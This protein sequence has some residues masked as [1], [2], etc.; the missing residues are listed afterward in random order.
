MS[1]ASPE[2]VIPDAPTAPSDE[3]FLTPPSSPRPDHYGSITSP[4]SPAP[5]TPKEAA[6]EAAKGGKSKSQRK[7]F[8]FRLLGKKKRQAEVAALETPSLAP[9][10]SGASSKASGTAATAKEQAPEPEI[11]WIL[12]KKNKPNRLFNSFRNKVRLFRGKEFRFW[13]FRSSVQCNVL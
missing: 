9:S 12:G 2:P 13:N 8:L 7:P 11:D 10:A 6:K 3:G 4:V 5:E 1:T